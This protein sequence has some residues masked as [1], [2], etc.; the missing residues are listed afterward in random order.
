VTAVTA[1]PYATVEVTGSGRTRTVVA[2]G[3]DGAAK[4]TYEITLTRKR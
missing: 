1:D 4:T 2:T 3:E